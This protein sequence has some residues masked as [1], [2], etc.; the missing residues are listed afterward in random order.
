V[1][2]EPIREYAITPHGAFEM[3]RRGLPED[4]LRWVL[5]HPEQRY[6]GRPGREVVQ[7]RVTMGASPKLYLVRVFLDVDRSPPEVVTAYRT[8]KIEKY[9]REEP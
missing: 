5:E 9:W 8:S 1:K 3:A 2:A 6:L 7:A 4:L